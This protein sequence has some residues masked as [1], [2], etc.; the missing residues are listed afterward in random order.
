M[1]IKAN[2][3]NCN[4]WHSEDRKEGSCRAHPPTAMLLGMQQ[5]PNMVKGLPPRPAEPLVM[6][7]FPPMKATG[8]CRD[9]EPD[10]KTEEWIRDRDAGV[11][12]ANPN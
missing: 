7:S 11:A 1:N 5:R 12:E 9:W 10:A 6:S 3:S 4:A 2:C 8:W